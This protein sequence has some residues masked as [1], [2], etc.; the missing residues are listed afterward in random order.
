[1]L[2][3]L[4][5]AQTFFENGVFRWNY[6]QNNR[7]IRVIHFELRTS[8]QNVLADVAAQDMGPFATCASVGTLM[9]TFDGKLYQ[10]TLPDCFRM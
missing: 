10:V 3:R 9:R 4:Y 1:M 5:T 8:A 6:R 2:S 7:N